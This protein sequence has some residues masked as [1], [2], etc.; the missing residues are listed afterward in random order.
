VAFLERLAYEMLQQLGL[1]MGAR[2]FITGGGANSRLWSQI[3]ASVLGK[4][5][6]RPAVAETAMGAAM[7]AASGCWYPD[8]REAAKNMVRVAEK[9]E[10][11]PAWQAAYAERYPAFVAELAR[12]GYFKE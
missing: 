5:L 8:L 6:L 11:V 10:P 3:R 1:E 7:L 9:I 12:R 2:V 4:V